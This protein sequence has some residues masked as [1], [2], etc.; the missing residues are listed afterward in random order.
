[1]A[2]LMMLIGSVE[3]LGN[4]QGSIMSAYGSTE[5][6]E[7]ILCKRVAL[8]EN[9]Y[10]EECFNKLQNGDMNDKSVW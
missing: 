4:L 8:P 5:M 1:M 10:C 6:I 7:C 3:K 9:V 2:V